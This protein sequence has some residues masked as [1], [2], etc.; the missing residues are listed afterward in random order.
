MAS[1]FANM[2]GQIG[3]YTKNS[4]CN[5]GTKE[6]NDCPNSKVSENSNCK[7]QTSDNVASSSKPL[8]LKNVSSKAEC[9]DT[10]HTKASM[11]SEYL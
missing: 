3:Q 9:Y 4:I 11:V 6:L 7:V 1:H 10:L 2:F 5:N 8:K